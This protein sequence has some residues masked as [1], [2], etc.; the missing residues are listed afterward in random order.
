MC[1][2]T[3]ILLL[4]KLLSEIFLII[5]KIRQ[6]FRSAKLVKQKNFRH[7]VFCSGIQGGLP[8]FLLTRKFQEIWKFAW[9]LLREKCSNLGFFRIRIV[10][11]FNWKEIISL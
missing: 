11:Y 9:Y 7:K 3:V 2:F 8:Q 6:T 4:K 10:P 1:N 5:E